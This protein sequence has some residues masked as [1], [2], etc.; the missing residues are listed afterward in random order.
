MSRRSAALPAALPQAPSTRPDRRCDVLVVGAGAAGLMAALSAR[1]VVG[2]SGEALPLRPDAPDVVL[3]T[4]ERRLGLKILVSGGGRCNVT[5]ATVDEQDYD[6]DAPHLVRRVL[7]G[8]PPAAVRALF[9]SRGCALYAEPLGKLFPRTD[10]ARSVLAVL[11]DEVEH[12]GIPLIAPAEVVDIARGPGGLLARLA[13][14]E[15]WQARRIVLASGGKSLPKSGSRGFG[16]T[17][18]ERLGHL[19]APALPGLSPLRFEPANPLGGLAGLTVPAIL[20]LSPEGTPADRLCG[21]R[22][23]PLARSGGSLLVTHRGATGPAPFD[24]SAACARALAGEGATLTGDFWS[25]TEPGGPWHPFRELAKPPGACLAPAVV[26]RPPT[27][28]AFEAQAAG[29]L[30]DRDRALG[31]VLSTRMPR[32]LVEALLEARGLDAGEPVRRLDPPKRAKLWLALT[33]AELRLCGV[34]GFDK[35]EVT[36]GGV[37]MRDLDPVSL[38]SRRVPGLHCCGEI[39]HATG[40]LGGFNFQWAWSSGFA[41]GRGAA[42]AI[43]RPG[44]ELATDVD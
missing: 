35:A 10:D 30:G 26:P 17:V 2:P 12:A 28:E 37:A 22:F 9:E 4:N 5:N 40:R 23:R 31:T 44:E 16:L 39:V 8:F 43:G 13:S 29:L 33:Q 18:L 41:A 32:S 20:T 6:T 3:L 36:A 25:L 11:L 27:R 38:E 15:V 14:G 19:M 34:E 7:R 1:G 24:V 21:K 42:A